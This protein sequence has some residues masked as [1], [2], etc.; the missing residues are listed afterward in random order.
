MGTPTPEQQAKILPI[1]ANIGRI[2]CFIDSRPMPAALFSC[3][4]RSDRKAHLRMASRHDRE[5]VVRDIDGE[6]DVLIRDSGI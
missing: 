1:N 4:A 3:F 5:R 6:R 2:N